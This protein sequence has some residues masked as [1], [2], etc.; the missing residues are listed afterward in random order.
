M[1]TRLVE[2]CSAA[3]ADQQSD[4]QPHPCCLPSLPS[5]LLVLSIIDVSVSRD[6]PTARR[7]FFALPEALQQ[8]RPFSLAGAVK[9]LNFGFFKR[10]RRAWDFW[11]RHLSLLVD[12]A[13]NVCLLE[14]SK[15]E[16][17]PTDLGS[18]HDG[19]NR[20]GSE[21]TEHPN[22]TVSIH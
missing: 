5:L 1:A 15:N 11:S 16:L 13:S 18:L 6:A 7:R 10:G 14:A 22:V 4:S 12:N 20:E 9:N 8:L 3:H 19:R 21:C 17:L 2:E